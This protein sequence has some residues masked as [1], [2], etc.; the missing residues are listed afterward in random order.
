MEIREITLADTEKF[1]ELIQKVENSS[2]F[3]LMEAGERQ[4]TLEQ[5]RKNLLHIEKQENAT[6]FVAEEGEHLVGYLMAVGGTVKRKRHS[7]YLVIGVLEA[8]R[9]K[10]IGTALFQ[11]LSEWAHA[12]GISRLELTVVTE[13]DGGVALY[14]KCG[15]EVE[16]TKR[17]SLVIDGKFYDEYYMSRL[18]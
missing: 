10:G 17:H 4:T 2:K 7:A 15:F 3:M 11:T 13:N 9:G 5:Q 1:I 18:L 6:I 12:K 16:G 8:H 14:K